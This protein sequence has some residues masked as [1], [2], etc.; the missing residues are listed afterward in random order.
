VYTLANLPVGPY[1]LEATLQGFTTFRRPGIDIQV[2]ANLVI[3]PVLRL[4]D[5][6]ETITVQARA[7]DVEVETR[8][9]GVGTVVEQERILELPLNARQVTDLITLSG[10]AVQLPASATATMVT[11][12]NISVAGG[13][14]FGVQYLLD[15]AMSNNRFDASNMPL[16]FPD[17]LED[18]ASA[19]ARRR[20]P[21]AVRPAP[22][23]TRSPGPAPTASMAT[24]SGSCATR[25][26]M[27]G[28]HTPR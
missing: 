8:R 18:S 9:M 6:T 7:S 12:V 25:S 5:I 21:S 3:D 15:G 14:R 28:R 17:A 11:G 19:P 27:P 23:S 20:L 24:R 13:A 4:G 1:R 16:P 10:A 22:R 2:N 26:S